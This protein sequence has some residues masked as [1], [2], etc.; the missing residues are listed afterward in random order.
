MMRVLPDRTHQF[1]GCFPRALAEKNGFSA[2]RS[3]SIHRAG[4]IYCAH[5]LTMAFAFGIGSLFLTHLPGL[6]TLC[7]QY[8]K[9]PSAA[10]AASTLLVFQPP[11]MDILRMYILFSF[12]TPLYFGLLES[13]M[14]DGDPHQ[15]VDLVD[16]AI[17]RARSSGHGYQGS[18]VDTRF[19]S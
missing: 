3:S 8:L 17:A 14:E 4:R 18:L 7:E 10:I 2:A 6:R 1:F 15:P 9:T 12:L 11:L 19:P 13:G 5:L 16:F